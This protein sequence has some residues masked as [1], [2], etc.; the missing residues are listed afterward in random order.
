MLDIAYDSRLKSYRPLKAFALVALSLVL[1]WA[2]IQWAPFKNFKSY[3]AQAVYPIYRCA[4][5]PF[6]L[7]QR[8]VTYFQDQQSLSQENH[9]LSLKLK[10][11]ESQMVA[12][13]QLYTENKALREMLGG[14]TRVPETTMLSRLLSVKTTPF[15]HQAILDKGSK[16]HVQLG[17]PIFDAQGVI[18][19]VDEVGLFQS[20]ALLATDPLM[21]I[22]V[23]S[24]RTGERAIAYGTGHENKLELKHVPFITSFKVGDTL[25][26]SG[27]G[28]I[29]P[30]GHFVG[31]VTQVVSDKTQKFKTFLVD[32][33]TKFDNR[34]YVFLIVPKPL[35]IDSVVEDPDAKS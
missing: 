8:W 6:E 4:D 32:H 12:A 17:Q 22:P 11:V 18:G 28:G 16:Q 25:V 27:L 19:L 24:S 33:K 20:R 2:D 29:F 13:K 1:L 26:T 15:A 9:R 34:Q 10:Q 31:M 21:A 35:A 14:Q 7:A 30:S 23:E 5:Y 3:L